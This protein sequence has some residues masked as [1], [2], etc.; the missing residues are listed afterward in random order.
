MANLTLFRPANGQISTYDSP[1]SGSI[2]LDFPAG[3]ATLAREGEGLTFTFDDG[4][5]INLEGF[6]T[7][8]SSENVPEFLVDGQA[9]SGKDFFT[10]LGHGELMPAA[11]PP[12][13]ERSAPH[14]EFADA[15]LASGVEHLDGLDW[16]M[17]SA[18]PGVDTL[19][20]ENLLVRDDSIQGPGAP[21]SGGSG[22]GDSV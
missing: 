13:A 18:A 4:S 12:N 20:T 21:E 2:L 10:A 16:Q 3:G 7:T 17:Q 15:S 5:K 9:F 14:N 6:Y 19:A 8:Y 11:G 1:G 22:W